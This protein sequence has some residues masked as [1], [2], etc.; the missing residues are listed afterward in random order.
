MKAAIEK[1]ISILENRKPPQERT[2]RFLY[3]AEARAA[4]LENERQAA[5][6]ANLTQKELDQR[7]AG[8]PGFMKA[9]LAERREKWKAKSTSG[10]TF[11]AD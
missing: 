1:R 9:I 7:E 2:I 4:D 11:L 8:L 5:E 6:T 10:K 3:G